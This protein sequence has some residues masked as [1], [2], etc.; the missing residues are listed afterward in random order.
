MV[1]SETTALIE[2]GKQAVLFAGA[3]KWLSS[4]GGGA[5]GC[6]S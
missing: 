2:R 6:R 1:S 5:R 3:Q 4:L